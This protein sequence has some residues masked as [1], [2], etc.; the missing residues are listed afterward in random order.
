MFSSSPVTRLFTIS[1]IVCI[2]LIA[3]PKFNS[4]AQDSDAKQPDTVFSNTSPIT[5]NTAPT[6]TAPTVASVYPSTIN[7]SGMTGTI[8]RVAVT[9]RGLT[10]TRTHNMDF[11][12]VSPTGAKFVFLSDPNAFV[13]VFPVN[14]GVYTFADDAT[15]SLI[16]GSPF[17]PGNYKPT[18][19]DTSDTFPSPAPAAPYNFPPSATFASVFNGADPNG[20]WSLYAVDDQIPAAGSTNSGWSLMI[21]TSSSPQQ[22]FTNSNHIGL[23]DTVTRATPYGSSITVSGMTGVISNLR[24]TVTGLSHGFPQEVDVLLVSPNGRSLILLSDAGTS[25]IN[26][27]NLTFDDSAAGGVSQT[28]VTSGTYK[29]TNYSDGLF[30][31]GDAFPSPAPLRPYIEQFSPQLSSFNGFNPNGDWRLL[32]T[33]DTGNSNS[34]MIAGGW[35]LDITTSPLQLPPLGCALP[36]FSVTTNTSVGVNPTNLAIGD[37]NNDNKQ[38]LVVTNQV[39]NDVSILLGNGDGTFAPQTLL[40]AGSSPY[41]VAVGRFNADNNDDLAIVNSGSNNVSILLGNGNGTFS[42]PTNFLVGASPISIAV[43][44]FNNDAKQDLAV[45]NFGGF[46]SGSVSILLGS[47]NGG[48]SPTAIVRTRTQPSYVATGNFNGDGNLDLVVAN[49]GADSISVF[50]GIG[51]GAFQLNQNLTTGAGPVAIEIANL[52]GDNF[53]DIATAN[54]NSDSST[55]F[56]GSANGTFGSG[57]SSSAGAN[58]ISLVAGDFLAGN[59]NRLAFALSGNNQVVV[60]FSNFFIVGSNPNAIAKGDFD[61]D[62]LVD[63]VTVNAGSNNVSVMRNSCKVAVGNLFDFNGDRRTDFSVFRSLTTGWFVNPNTIQT[64]FARETDRLV[65]ADYDGDSITDFGIY[66]PESGLWFTVSQTVGTTHHFLQFG[67]LADIPVPVDYDGDRK[68]DIAVFRPSDGT[69]YI[70]RSSDN[71]LQITQWGMNGDKPAPA[72]YDGDNKADLAVFRPSN[73]VWYILRSSDNQ[74]TF[75]NFGIGT[76]KL[77]PNDYD[78]DG[79]ADIAV[80]RDGIWYVLR[81]S[82]GGFSAIGFGMLG[83]ISVPG[84]YDGDGKFDFAIFRPGDSRW[85]VMRSTDGGTLVA[86]FGSSTDIPLPSTVVR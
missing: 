18:N 68:A 31:N 17:L 45:A 58:P 67:L 8:T 52:N 57:G 23:D 44:D 64:T 6:T 50:F 15:T 71:S 83:D 55:V 10:H 77:I 66:R 14:D 38:D 81:S 32:V 21:T 78:G 36:S 9:L 11:L 1:L 70:R 39:S 35:S 42:A 74:I 86:P 60:Q 26:N 51:G 40:N 29:P 25:S 49:F 5:I 85:W 65:P 41:D 43:G 62:T 28:S 20:T 63:L 48:F 37:F 30:E 80:Y 2:T 13:D 47:G 7:V 3:F 34:G 69:W 27:V 24:V 79:K 22:T 75:A 84:D 53:P 12:L 73:G 76:D 54:Y 33:D 82:D 16:N 56:N 61:R 19:N 59:Q 72:D 46:F 4:Q